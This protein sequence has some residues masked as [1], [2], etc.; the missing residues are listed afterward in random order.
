VGIQKDLEHFVQK[1]RIDNLCQRHQLKYFETSIFTREENKE[2][3]SEVATQL[4][5]IKL[6]RIH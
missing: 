3:I 5:E 1:N 6:N 4:L 2:M